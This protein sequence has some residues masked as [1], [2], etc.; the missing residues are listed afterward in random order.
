MQATAD[1]ET[2][3]DETFTVTLSNAAGGGGQAPTLGA[4]SVSTTL[5]EVGITLS[6]GTT[7]LSE[8]ASA[9]EITVTATLDEGDKRAS[10]VTVSISLGG[11]AGSGDYSAP[12]LSI[13]IEA[14][15]SSGS[16][17]LTITPTDDAI[18]EH[19][20]TITVGG[21]STGIAVSSAEITLTD[22]DTATLSI[23]GPS[24][25]VTEG[26]NAVF[27]IT[28]SNDVD[29]DI[30]VAVL[31]IDNSAVVGADM[32]RAPSPTTFT[33]GSGAG[34][35]RTVS[36]AILD[37]HISEDPENFSLKLGSI[38]GDL[39]SKVSLKSDE[40]SARATIALNDLITFNVSGPA[41]VTEGETATYTISMSPAGVVPPVSAT[42]SLNYE[43][44]EGTAIELV[45]SEN[46]AV[47]DFDWKSD[48]HIFT[49]GSRS[50]E[51]SVQTFQDTRVEEDETFDFKISESWFRYGAGSATISVPASAR[52]RLPPPSLTTTTLAVTSSL[53]SIL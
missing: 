11:T 46:R 32:A 27:T 13:T 37:D 49:S 40:S 18:V 17:T 24:G 53:A 5:Q 29:S 9:T 15:D 2:E 1:T 51:V 23:S 21:S 48:I 50:F 43:T 8:S 28:L 4:S 30:S 42:F 31:N 14:G 19:T 33:A 36:V 7:T 34:A 25:E 52:R 35:T 45:G 38:T 6:V 10:D 12:A 16:G 26:S 22:N 3:G 41:S 39:A 47:A 44:I 20:E